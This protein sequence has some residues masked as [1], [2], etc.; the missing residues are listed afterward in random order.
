MQSL[1]DSGVWVGGGGVE[2]A[3]AICWFVISKVVYL[4]L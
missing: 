4:L 1:Y 2:N 3:S